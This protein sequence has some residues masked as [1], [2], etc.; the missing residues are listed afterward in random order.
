MKS[1]I[2]FPAYAML[3]D[4]PHFWSKTKKRS[5]IMAAAL[6]DNRTSDS[7]KNSE[8]EYRRLQKGKSERILVKNAKKLHGMVSVSPA[9][10]AMLPILAAVILSKKPVHL[11]NIPDL[12]DMHALISIL[13]DMGVK[14]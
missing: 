12:R 11:I 2:N 7:I 10:N 9:K 5:P 3:M 14:V 8:K 6:F 13:E 1:T 4:M